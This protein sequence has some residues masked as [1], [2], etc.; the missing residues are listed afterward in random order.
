M[1]Q[2]TLAEVPEVLAPAFAE[3]DPD[4]ASKPQER[5]N[6]DCVSEMFCAIRE[7]RFGDLA[8]FMTP[9]VTLE[10]SAPD[11]IPYEP[12]ARGPEQVAAAVA[13][14]FAQA[15]E[16]RP[17]PLALVAQG[18]TVMAMARETGRWADGRPYH[19]IFSQQ[20][21][22][23]DGRLSLFRA[24]AAEAEGTGG[25]ARGPYADPSHQPG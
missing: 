14:N 7:G 16:Q 13:R 12:F 3:G 15:T 8:A 9:D 23:R 11:S 5:R 6:V 10:I 2:V 1:R 4:H 17:E 22:F 24:V 18:D 20:Y 21:T 19:I 25:R